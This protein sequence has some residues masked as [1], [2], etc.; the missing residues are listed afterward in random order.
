[1]DQTSLS[2]RGSCSL[3]V[4]TCRDMNLHHIRQQFK[5][6]VL[7]E[8]RAENGRDERT[9]CCRFR[10]GTGADATPARSVT[11]AREKRTTSQPETRRVDSPACASPSSSPGSADATPE[12]L[13][14]Y[15]HTQSQHQRAQNRPEVTNLRALASPAR[16]RSA[17]PAASAR[18]AWSSG[19][20]PMPPTNCPRA[21]QSNH[22]RS[23][24]L[25]SS[26]HATQ[27]GCCDGQRT[28]RN[29]VCGFMMARA[30]PAAARPAARFEVGAAISHRFSW[31]ISTISRG[32][33]ASGRIT[34][35]RASSPFE[36]PGATTGAR[37]C[38]T[39]NTRTVRAARTRRARL[40]V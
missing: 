19:W 31:Q 4:V 2:L 16:A 8:T 22:K 24:Q 13:H 30:E 9:R 29:L 38:C 33:S 6:D 14:A 15:T 35:H 1:M 11:S 39:R 5:S 28:S 17:A 7:T 25:E 27:R 18:A 20:A 37:S 40:F 21:A 12:P 26:E 34:Y 3:Q 36:V 10:T 23:G 32:S